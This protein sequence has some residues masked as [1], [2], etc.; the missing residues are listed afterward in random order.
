M[1]L[2]LPEPFKRRLVFPAGVYFVAHSA[3]PAL[4]DIVFVALPDLD[5]SNTPDHEAVSSRWYSGPYDLYYPEP[6]LQIPDFCKYIHPD[7]VALAMDSDHIW[8]M[9]QNVPTKDDDIWRWVDNTQSFMDDLLN[10][11]SMRLDGWQMP[12]HDDWEDSLFIR[13]SDGNWKHHSEVV[14]RD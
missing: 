3:T 4:E 6:K 13:D 2:L 8:Y 11:T 9:Y 14:S 12:I 10:P 5:F 7:Y 1:D